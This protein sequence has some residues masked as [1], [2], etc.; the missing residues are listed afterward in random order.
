M[1]TIYLIGVVVILFYYR[2][3]SGSANKKK[4]MPEMAEKILNKSKYGNSLQ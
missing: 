4:I 1:N 3:K 2:Y